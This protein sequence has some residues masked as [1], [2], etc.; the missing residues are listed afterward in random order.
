L[1]VD[2][3]SDVGIQ[4]REGPGEIVAGTERLDEA[5]LAER[6]LLLRLA[7]LPQ[8]AR[9]RPDQRPSFA[10]LPGPSRAA[11]LGEASPQI[12]GPL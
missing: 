5:N 8:E 3:D 4:E 7:H 12:T 1:T 9:R 10:V 11:I 6:C 2:A